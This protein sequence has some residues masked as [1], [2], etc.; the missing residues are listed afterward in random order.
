[1]TGA[2]TVHH[3][4]MNTGAA[5]GWKN[6]AGG[7]AGIAVL[8]PLPHRCRI[9]NG[10]TRVNVIRTARKRNRQFDVNTIVISRA[11]P[12]PES[13]TK[14]SLFLLLAVNRIMALDPGTD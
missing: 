14:N 13:I 3:A 8:L 10:N 12:Y 7:I 6:A 1:M 4:G 5:S 9:T 11:S 2:L